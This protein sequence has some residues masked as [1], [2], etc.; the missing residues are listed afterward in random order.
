MTFTKMF[1]STSLVETLSWLLLLLILLVSRHLGLGRLLFQV[2]ISNLVLVG[3][4]FFFST[5]V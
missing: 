4:V 1:N 3:W 2:F 5:R